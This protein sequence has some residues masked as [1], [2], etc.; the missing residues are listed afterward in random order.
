MNESRNTFNRLTDRPLL[1]T[2]FWCK[3]G[4]HKWQKWSEP[5]KENSLSLYSYQKRFCD[6]CNIVDTKQ[7]DKI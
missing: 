5:F 1:V 7:I 6:S 3:F 4:I 2:S